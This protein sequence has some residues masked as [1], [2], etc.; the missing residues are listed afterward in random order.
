ITEEQ[1]GFARLPVGDI[2]ELFAED[3]EMKMYKRE[4]EIDGLVVDP[5]KAVHIV[6]GVT[7]RELC[8]YFFSPQFREEWEAT[9]EQ[10]TVLEKISEDI[11]IFLQLHKRIWPASQRDS[12]FWSH[13]QKIKDISEDDAPEPSGSCVRILLTVIF[14]CDTF[15]NNGKKASNC[16]REDISCKITYCS[17]VNPGGWVPATALRTIYKREYPKFLKRLTKYVIEKTKNNP[18]MW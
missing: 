18:I 4:E 5:L 11:L 7:A 3:G 12:L 6:K 10:A 13:R 8:Y 2:W 9:V 14:L 1:L 16:S 17:V 15:I